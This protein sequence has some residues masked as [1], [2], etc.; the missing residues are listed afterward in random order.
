VDGRQ[1]EYG[2]MISGIFNEQFIEQ[3]ADAVAARISPAGGASSKR[4]FT[5]GEAS[6]YIG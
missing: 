2:S 4:L 3:L 1:K 5:L 6:D